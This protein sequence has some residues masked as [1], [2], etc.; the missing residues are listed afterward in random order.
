[1]NKSAGS[2]QLLAAMIIRSLP[3]IGCIGRG[4]ATGSTVRVYVEDQNG[5]CG[6]LTLHPGPG[7]TGEG[8][9]RRCAPI[10]DHARRRVARSL[11]SRA[12]APLPIP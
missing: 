7:V 1:M 3:A 9:V 10:L 5:P 11:E 2:P 8:L 12:A 6:H 4:Y